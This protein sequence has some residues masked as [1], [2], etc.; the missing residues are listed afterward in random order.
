LPWTKLQDF[1][2]R[3]GFLKVIAACLSAERRSVA[4]DSIIRRLERPLFDAVGDC[5]ELQESAGLAARLTARGGRQG[6]DYRAVE[7]VEA[8]AAQA[9][10]PSALY[11]VTKKTAYKILDWARD[12]ELVVRANQ[13]SERALILKSLLPH[14]RVERFFGG[15]AGAWNPF[16][17]TRSERIFFLYHAVDRD[18]VT[19]ELVTSLAEVGSGT[20]IEAR[21]ASRMTCAALFKVLEANER[22]SDAASIQAHRAALDLTLTMADEVDAPV[23]PH[24]HKHAQARLASNARRP[25]PRTSIRPGGAKSVRKTTKNADHQTIPRFEQLVDLGFLSKPGAESDDPAASLEARRRWRYSPTEAC[26]RWM[27]GLASPSTSLRDDFKYRGFARA[28]LQAFDASPIEPSTSPAPLDVATR[29][30]IAYQVVGRAVGM[31]P[32]DTIALRVM[33]DAAADGVVIEMYHVHRLL[34]I[35]KSRALMSDVALFAAGTTI[36]TMFV[37]LKESFLDRIQREL[38]VIAQEWNA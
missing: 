15:D 19:V 23:P 18:L 20:T 12:V 17:L 2:L 9:A 10:V 7:V 33:L 26:K 37:R 31:T 16:Q 32:V 29:T 27:R 1:Y 11:A 6:R 13:I 5:P 36:D 35:I 3:L 25:S 24:W 38:Q 14:D 28:A 30:W 8:L 22:Q 34:L 4:A 21:D